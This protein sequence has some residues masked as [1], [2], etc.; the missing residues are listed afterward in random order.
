M[1]KTQRVLNETL[2]TWNTDPVYIFGLKKT[3]P[4]ISILY[5]VTNI[6]GLF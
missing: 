2:G 3:K 6:Y 1:T 5:K 4:I